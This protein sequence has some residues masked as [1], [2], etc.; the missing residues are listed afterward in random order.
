MLGPV[1]LIFLKLG[2]GFSEHIQYTGTLMGSQ[3]PVNF[4]P[5]HQP[6]AGFTP[7]EKGCTMVTP[8]FRL[9]LVIILQTFLTDLMGSGSVKCLHE[10]VHNT[11]SKQNGKKYLSDN[12][13]LG[14]DRIGKSTVFHSSMQC[15]S[16]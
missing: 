7:H 1:N 5:H 14:N 13:P 10:S 8:A 4:I 16:C 12:L 15:S 3:S 11:R 2:A 6:V 9:Y